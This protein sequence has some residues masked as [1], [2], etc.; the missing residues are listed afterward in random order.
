MT[1]NTFLDHILTKHN[2][3]RLGLLSLFMIHQSDWM[4]LK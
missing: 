4:L 3:I 2:I 1:L